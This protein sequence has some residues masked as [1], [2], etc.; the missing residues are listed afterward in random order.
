MISLLN[1]FF[2]F[3]LPRICPG[4]NQKL[5]NDAN[6]V[7]EE[8]LSSILIADEEKLEQE[9][10]KNFKSSGIITDYYALYIFQPDQAFQHIVHA[11]KYQKH[12]RI[13][14]FLGEMLSY[15]IKSRDWQ[16]DIIIPIPIHHLK[17]VE[18]GY[19]Q[20]DYI[21]KGLSRKLNIPWSGKIVNRVRHT[22]SQTKLNMKQ[23]ALNIADAFKVK[24]PDEIQNK[25]ILV[26]DDVSTT[27]AT[28][29]ECAKTIKE[30]GA[31]TIFACTVGTTSLED[32]LA[33]SSL[34]Q[35]HQE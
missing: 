21:A 35:K 13:G 6:P 4:C 19:N 11:L 18:R 8:C 23:R 28:I 1:Q 31:K 3:F 7:C 12:F 2:D 14:I 27:G 32:D 22:E 24:R 30:A 25:N 5:T 15:G 33:T 34:A 29:L 17:K 9:F 16:I 10:E 26:V 20:S